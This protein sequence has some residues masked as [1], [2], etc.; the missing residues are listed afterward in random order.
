ME[1]LTKRWV[2]KRKFDDIDDDQKIKLYLPNDI[3][4]KISGIVFL[5]KYSA[6]LLRWIIPIGDIIP[7]NLWENRYNLDQ[8]P[9]KRFYEV[10]EFTIKL[11]DAIKN[12]RRQ[13]L[14]TKV[15][16][17]NPDLKK[18]ITQKEYIIK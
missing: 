18:I 14:I 12:N 13:E 3:W 7:Y 11:A 9:I 5:L 6:V 8:F 15:I 2:K 16:E 1:Y 10:P 17:F 4:H